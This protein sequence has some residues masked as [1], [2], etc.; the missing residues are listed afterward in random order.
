MED[1]IKH[2]V[3]IGGG[4]TGLSAAY[5][6]KKYSEERGIP[7]KLTVVEKAERMGGKIRTLHRDGCVIEQG[8]DSFMARKLP[9]L[10]LTKELG[11]MDELT[12]TNPKAKQNYILHRG[13]LHPMPIGFV[14]GVPTAITPFLKTGL[15]SPL[16]KARAALDLILPRSRSREDE[17]L[18]GFIERRLGKEVLRQI[19]EPLLAGIYAGDTG[20]LSLH[21]TFPQFRLLEQ[22]HRSLILGLA[23]GK[24]K[25]GHAGGNEDLP[26]I[27]KRS[28]FLTYKGG[29]STLINELIE[30]LDRAQLITGCGVASLSREERERGYR[31]QL[32]NGAVLL[33][34]GVILAAPAYAAA[35]LLPDIKTLGWMKRVP[36]VSVAN[37]V[38]AY[39]KADIQMPLNGSGFVVPSREGRTIT[40]CTW[41]SSKWLHTAPED[42]V[43]LRAY[44]GRAGAE[45]WTKMPDDELLRRVR[46]DLYETM[47]LNAKPIFHEVTRLKQSMPQ[48]PVGHVEELK[49]VRAQLAEDRP[50]IMLCGAGYEGVGIPDCIEQ[51]RKAA[52]QMASFC[53]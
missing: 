2:V 40:A 45:E 21:A 50:G 38:L 17:S 24:K 51:G 12:A 49:R 27:A 34:D 20:A 47:G 1:T 4:I 26:E 23:S 42:T 36:Y 14:L 32:D 31:V 7:L 48:Y 46:Q 3:V 5:Y 52:E 11:L 44:I 43:L 18:G 22:K 19:T 9:V 29:L 8:P 41:I 35:S 33:A 53:S 15:V 30:R 10:T 13:K 16:G 39:R 28:L 37:I 6:V 25:G